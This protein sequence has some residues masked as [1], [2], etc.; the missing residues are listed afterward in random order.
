MLI[1]LFYQV[2][3][4][5][6]WRCSANHQQGMFSHGVRWICMQ[7]VNVRSQ[8]AAA[9]SAT[10]LHIPV[11]SL[12]MTRRINLIDE[13]DVNLHFLW[14]D[15]LALLSRCPIISSAHHVT[16]NKQN[17]NLWRSWAIFH[18]SGTDYDQLCNFDLVEAWNV[19]LCFG[20]ETWIGINDRLAIDGNPEWWMERRMHYRL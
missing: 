10:K 7:S 13:I 16:I 1:Y 11:I 5:Q 3:W 2:W 6:H 17:Q 14:I 18:L 20:P 19:F 9:I 8:A 12:S 4:S 15:Y